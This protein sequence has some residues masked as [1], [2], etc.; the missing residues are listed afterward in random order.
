MRYTDLKPFAISKFSTVLSSARPSP[1][2]L[3]L[4]LPP[5]I[6]GIISLE[7]HNPVASAMP[8]NTNTRTPNVE[9]VVVAS[10]PVPV[11]VRKIDVARVVK[12]C[13]IPV[14]FFF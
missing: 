6:I 12:P 4:T 9:I 5:N 8:A 14:N 10:E 3:D 1:F 11:V 7:R 2:L 13:P